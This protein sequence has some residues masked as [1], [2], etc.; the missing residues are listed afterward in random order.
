LHDAPLIDSLTP[1][2]RHEIVAPKVRVHD[3][4]AALRKATAGPKN[5]RKS[6]KQA[7]NSHSDKSAKIS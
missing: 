5:Q 1:I 2:F 4:T 3:A 6:P 7:E